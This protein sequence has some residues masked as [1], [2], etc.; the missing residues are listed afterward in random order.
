ML[1]SNAAHIQYERVPIFKSTCQS[2]IILR[3]RAMNCRFHAHFS[4]QRPCLDERSTPEARARR[5][6]A[7]AMIYYYRRFNLLSI[8]R[9]IVMHYFAA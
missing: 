7:L 3:S 4:G 5:R 9:H 2:D 6:R 8:S 1:L